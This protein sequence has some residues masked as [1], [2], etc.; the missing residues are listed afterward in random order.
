MGNVAEREG[1]EPSEPLRVHLISSQARSAAPAPLQSGFTLGWLVQ[2]CQDMPIVCVNWIRAYN[3]CKPRVVFFSNCS[4]EYLLMKRI[5]KQ[6]RHQK[7]IM[8]IEQAAVQTGKGRK[9]LDSTS[10][11]EE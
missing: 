3:S 8:D 10:S 5:E 4:G 1:F 6:Y 7:R 11:L 2:W 9:V